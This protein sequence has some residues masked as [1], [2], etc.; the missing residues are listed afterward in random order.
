MS[1]NQ[2][3]EVIN[4]WKANIR[5]NDQWALRAFLRIWKEQTE[6]EKHV[7]TS[8]EHNGVGFNKYDAKIASSFYLGYQKYGKLTPKQYLTLRKIMPKYTKQLYRLTNPEPVKP[9]APISD[10]L[11]SE[12]EAYLEHV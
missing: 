4:T 11:E 10:Q 2:A 9:A 12:I 8:E 6:E 3:N 1:T 5:N 7:G